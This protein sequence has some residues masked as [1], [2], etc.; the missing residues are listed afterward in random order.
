[1]NDLTLPLS[2]L[3]S[4]GGK[5]V[6]ARFD[7]GMLS[8]NSGVL[9][10]A[11]VEKRL[12]VAERLARCIDDPRCR[13]QTAHSLAD[14]IGFRMKMIAAGYED[15]NDANRLRC[16]PVFKMAQDALPSGRDLASQS[17][18]CRLENLPG[19]RELVAMGRAMVDLYCASFRQVPKRI[20]LDLDDT[21]DAVHGGQQLRLFNA[22]YDEYGFQPIVVF[23]GDGRFVGAVLRPAKRPSGA[24]IRP[25]LRRLV[26]AIRS[27]WPNTRILIRADSHYC[28]P[29]VID[30]C[31]A[32]DVDFILG[33]AHVADL[34]A[35]TLAR[36]E[37]SE[38]TNKV[39]R[40]KEFVDGAASWSRDERIIARVEVG[41]QGTDTRFIVTN[42]AGG[43]AK[44]LYEDLYCRRGAAENH[45]KS[46]KT[47]L[48]ADRTSCTGATANQFR[49]FL[50][51]GAYWLMWSL[52]AAMPK[53]SSFAVAQF[54]TLRLRLIKIA[55][56][57]VEMK[58]QIRLHLPTSCPD[59]R[60]LRIVLDRIPRLVT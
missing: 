14:I 57:V 21:F 44:A 17:T 55:A 35:S 28:S 53:R 41:A 10:L 37:V 9:A 3:S 12:R 54:D 19:V 2:G 16:D 36:F 20:V 25:H 56:R 40:F 49:L 48:A 42:L 52:R 45:I 60:I 6:V 59:Q 24:E 47:H 8:S 31:R 5:S 39:R 18:M 4:V 26:Q 30:W 50:H 32:N 27:N 1:M 29:P 43:K 7:G 15:G 58:T 22:H 38:K 51:A 33:L 46:W 13:D 23:D 11:E 34:E